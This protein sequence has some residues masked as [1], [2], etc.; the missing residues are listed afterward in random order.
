MS[1][2]EKH[3]L[4]IAGGGGGDRRLSIL[5]ASD[6]G[7]DVDIRKKIRYGGP[8]AGAVEYTFQVSE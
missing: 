8:L 6:A 4:S 1:S 7:S 3:R 2:K 5:S